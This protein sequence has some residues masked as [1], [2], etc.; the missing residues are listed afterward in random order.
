HWRE[1][2]DGWRISLTWSDA[3]ARDDDMTISLASENGDLVNILLTARNEPFEGINETINLQWDDV[4]A[5]I[6]DFRAMTVWKG[7]I[8][9]KSRYWPKDVGHKRAVLQPFAQEKRPWAEV[10]LSSLLMLRIAE[11]VRSAQTESDFFFSK[12]LMALRS[13]TSP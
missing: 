10:E 2:P 7:E 9:K 3:A 6:D 12:E 13:A 4:I 11:M 8:I 1:L 5:K